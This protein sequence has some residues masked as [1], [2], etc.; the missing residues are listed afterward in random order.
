MA[1]D[2]KKETKTITRNRKALHNYFV[3]E[4]YEA[5][6]VL[7]G[8]EVKS[9]RDARVQLTDA[10][11]RFDRNELWLV[12]AHISPYPYATHVNHEP[13]RPRKLLLHRRELNRLRNKVE[14]AGYTLI[15]LELYFSGSNV[16]VRIGLCRGKKLFDK[17]E[18]VRKREAAREIARETADAKRQWKD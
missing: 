4:E 12:S 3:D 6:I 14:T 16:K 5:G 2:A 11:A 7:Y 1:N 9:L 17:R 15:P 10:Y 18:S 13:E 8:S